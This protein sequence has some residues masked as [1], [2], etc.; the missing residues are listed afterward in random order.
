MEE[1]WNEQNNEELTDEQLE[2]V[3]G[4]ACYYTLLG[5]KC[6]KC[7]KVYGSCQLGIPLTC[8][9]GNRLNP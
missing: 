3:A 6:S 2:Q 8:E 9:C 1:N 7:G 4:G 5:A